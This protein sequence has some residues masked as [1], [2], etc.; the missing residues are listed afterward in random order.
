MSCRCATPE[1][2]HTYWEVRESTWGKLKN[3]LAKLFET[4]KKVLRVYDVSCINFNGSNAHRSFD[5]EIHQN[6]KSW[7]IDT[8]G[9]GRS[10]CVDVGLKLSD[11]RFIT[12]VRSNIVTTPLDA[13]SWVTD[14]EWMVP[15]E[16]FSRLYTSS[17]G[18]GVHRLS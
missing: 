16:L 3:E 9:P 18:L 11:G 13:P 10:W 15:D 4:A 6:A 8:A 2:L 12:I 14:E 1:W 5:I 7:Y 17:V